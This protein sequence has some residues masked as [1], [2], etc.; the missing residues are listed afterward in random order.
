MANTVHLAGSARLRPRLD[1]FAL[2]ARPL[3]QS[4]LAAPAVVTAHL[5]EAPLTGSLAVALARQQHTP[6][7]SR[8]YL[9][10]AELVE[11]HGSADDDVAAVT[12]WAS[13]A[14]LRARRRAQAPTTLELS[15][16]LGALARAFDVTLEHRRERDALTGA[17]AV[18]RDHRE[19]LSV[20]AELDGVVTA[21]LGLSDRP[22]GRPR[23]ALLPRGRS[24]ACSYSPEELA[25]IYDFPVLDNGG[26]GLRITVGIAE[27]GGAV[28]RPDL[29]AFTA[30]NPRLRVVE[31]AV[32]GWGPTSDPFGP[33]TEVALD[34]QVIAGV[35]AYCAPQA[36]VLVVIKYAPNT[37]RGFS[38]MEASF[39]TDGRDYLAVSTSWGAPE[40]RWTPAAMDAMDRAFQ[41][42]ALR[43]TVHSVAA[44]DNGST[45]A[46]SDGRQ[47]ADHPAS[48][49]HAVG[50]GGTRLVAERG[51]R[52]SEEAWNEL[53]VT[54]GAT[55]GGVS[56]HFGVPRYQAAAG[57]HPVSVN[58]GRPGRGVPDVAGNADPLTGYVVH[59]RGVD[60]VVGGT[61]AVAPLWT[62]LFAAV[63]A[64]TGRRLGDVLPSLYG[65]RDVGFTDVTI[66]DNGAYRAGRGWDASTGLGAP[67]GRSL[68][69]A[70]RSS[71]VLRRRHPAA[72]AA[73]MPAEVGLGGEGRELD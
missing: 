33:D 72:P 23:L 31:E 18:Y 19:E 8:R 66:G 2:S 15:G 30:R 7:Q 17:L 67:S 37:D 49:P 21:A 46:R 64:S 4:E 26:E 24:T 50:C 20:P 41:M 3:T 45:D 63:S 69:A 39:A 44:G 51:R 10:S 9:S 54:Q 62:A 73:E 34:W 58:D 47:H 57:I 25:R 22:V 14:G 56:E 13:E 48:A 29:E 27:L 71:L 40:D 12:R 5:R 1:A 28:H 11:A 53:R 59:H 38:N 70:L 36:D 6:V 52:V 43:G 16:S 35:L 65:A 32:H 60:T 61:S 55:G 42:G 68:C